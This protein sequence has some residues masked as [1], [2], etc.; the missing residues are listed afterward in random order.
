M[1]DEKPEHLAGYQARDYEVVDYQLYQLPNTKLTFRGP[2]V[3]LDDGAY[4]S[5]LGAAQ[6]FGCFVDLPYPKILADE[7]QR[8]TLNLGYGGAGPLFFNRHPELI[9]IVNRGSLAVVQ[10]MSGRSED[11][12]RFESRGLEFLTRRSD[13][14]QMSADA[15][16]RSILEFRYAWKRFPIG[17]G[18]A[19]QFCRRIGATDAKRLLAETRENWVESYQ[20]LL[21]SITVPTVLLWFS[22][23]SPEFTE[24]Y[25]NL[26]QFMGTYPQL[27]TR[28]MVDAIRHESNH[29]VE[30]TTQRGSP[31][32]LVNRFDGTDV[33]IDLGRDR[34]DFAGQTWN[35]NRYYPSPEMHEDAAK[36]LAAN[37]GQP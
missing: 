7:L 15:A 25:E 22:K 19:R 20:Q 3:E 29:Y 37:I 26:H 8:P 24:S 10:I 2:Q 23:R 17:Q 9:E 11:N 4:V 27:V 28:E 31:Q 34:P 1:V 33:T 32:R 18:I 21:R 12:S 5:C 14:R 13:G 30:C 36:C 16:W 35:E 6:T